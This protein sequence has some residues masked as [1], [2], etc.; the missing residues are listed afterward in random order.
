VKRISEALHLAKESQLTFPQEGV[1]ECTTSFSFVLIL[2]HYVAH[3]AS[4][5]PL[6]LALMLLMFNAPPYHSYK[7]EGGGSL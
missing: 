7:P 5:K 2:H 6:H 4:M 3:V 1:A